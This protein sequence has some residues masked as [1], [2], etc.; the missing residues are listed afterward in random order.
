MPEILRASAGHGGVICTPAGDRCGG[1]R[2]CG[3]LHSGAS[4]RDDNA[5]ARTGCDRARV[6]WVQGW[7]GVPILP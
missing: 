5:P 6:G 3:N 1:L 4:R 2:A 7:A